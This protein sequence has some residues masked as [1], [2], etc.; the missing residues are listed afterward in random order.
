MN[1]KNNP[2]SGE[3]TSGRGSDGLILLHCFVIFEYKNLL[4][5]GNTILQ[6]GLCFVE[7]VELNT[8]N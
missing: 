4:V 1:G 3:R 8:K 2:T 5:F 7:C 6:G